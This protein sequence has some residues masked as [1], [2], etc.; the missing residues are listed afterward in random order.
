MFRWFKKAETRGGLPIPENGCLPITD[1][2]VLFQR[3]PN[4]AQ[5]AMSGKQLFPSSPLGLFAQEIWIL[6][7]PIRPT[8]MR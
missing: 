8:M 7:I 3:F 5:Q 1:D 6:K 2:R 4:V